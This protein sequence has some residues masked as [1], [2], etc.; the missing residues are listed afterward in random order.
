MK[1]KLR[2]VLEKN[3]RTQSDLAELLGIKYQT[4][5]M[6]MNC[7]TDFTQSEIYFIKAYFNLEPEEVVD[8]FFNEED[9]Y[10]TT[11]SI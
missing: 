9:R 3:G 10:S 4:L 7:H 1:N 2:A 11:G 6:K 8:I 5:S